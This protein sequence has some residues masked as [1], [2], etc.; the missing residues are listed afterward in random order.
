MSLRSTLQAATIMALALPALPVWTQPPPIWTPELSMRVQRIGE[1]VPS[2][3]G[4]LVVYTQARAIIEPERNEWATQIFL[5]KADA[6]R[7]FQLT[8]ERAGIS[9]PSF[10]PDGQFIYF[11][12]TRQGKGNIYR[13]RVDGEEAEK[14]TDWKGELTKY[15]VSPDG[16]WIVFAGTNANEE[17]E[18]E[19]K[20]KRDW[21]VVDANPKVNSLW[22]LSVEPDAQGKRPIRR[23]I[24]V[25]CYVTNFDWSPE[26][27]SIAFEHQP[28]ASEDFWPQSDLSEVDLR[29]GA[30]R[31]LAGT[32]AAEGEP[33]Y[34]PDGRWLA[35]LRTPD[36]AHWA[37]EEQIVLFPRHGGAPRAVPSTFDAPSSV[38][39]VFPFRFP[40]GLIPRKAM[41]EFL[42]WSSDSARL[43]F[44]GEKGTCHL[45]YSVSPDGTT[46]DVYG[47][48]DAV[49]RAA[50][51]NSTGT[52]VGFSRESP[53]EPQ[54]AFT[55][56]LDRGNP[57][58]VSATNSDLPKVPTG[59]TKLIN[60]RSQDGLEIEGLLT[61]PPGYAAGKK[62]PLVVAIHGG[63]MGWWS[64]RFNGEATVFCP[65]AS[66]AGRGYAI[67]E[68]NIRGSGGY[69]RGFRFANLNDWGGKDYEDLMA[70]VDHVIS[71]GVADP[72]RLAVM[73]WSYG[74]YMTSWV[75][76]HTR[77]FKAA[78]D[79]AGVTD[80][81]SFTG[82]TDISSFLPDYFSG[83]FWNRLAL[84]QERSPIYHVKGVT[85]P[86]LILQGEAD[87]RVPPSQS[88][89]LYD[90]L[91]RQGITTQMVIYPGEE[92]VPDAPRD[93]MDIM[94]RQ[95]EWVERYTH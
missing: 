44:T 41:G 61:L 71:M 10:S 68:P 18:K 54:E 92:H 62:Y 13:I 15:Q 64:Q 33:R 36:P 59:T 3:D 87:L 22:I 76:T 26:A 2:P 49:V 63:P 65:V 55:M 90:A 84:Y 91:K 83:E 17:S 12:S 21:R 8:H 38:S 20:E 88:F 89:E 95:I 14:L 82:T 57:I 16:K 78:V 93:V 24:S 72:G 80:L 25:S 34:S 29:S 47:P 60:W 69:G 40:A 27:L 35:Y 42:G 81:I 51:L 77:R 37:G 67:L 94:Q 5:A 4:R 46:K 73:G 11:L 28:N 85:T 32:G 74:G 9:S 79:G 48:P 70:G 19:R 50:S 1:V 66:L 30:V 75:I 43:F 45:L 23:L 56:R 86:T 39:K 52:Y 31:V 53:D 6:T 7:R 58:Q